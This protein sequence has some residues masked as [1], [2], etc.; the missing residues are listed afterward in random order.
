M[1]T[2]HFRSTNELEKYSRSFSAC[3]QPFTMADEGYTEGMFDKV[4]TCALLRPRP[5]QVPSLAAPSQTAV[6]QRGLLPDVPSC[7]RA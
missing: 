5:P 2:D 6:S 4:G 3:R 7:P 1:L